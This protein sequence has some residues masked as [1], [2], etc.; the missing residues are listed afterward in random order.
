MIER[1]LIGDEPEYLFPQTGAVP[2]LQTSLKQLMFSSRPPTT[3]AEAQQQLPGH[4]IWCH[5]QDGRLAYCVLHSHRPDAKGPTTDLAAIVIMQG[6]GQTGV[7]A[8]RFSH[9]PSSGEYGEHDVVL[10]GRC[11]NVLPD[12]VSMDRGYYVDIND[13]GL[14]RSPGVGS[15][16]FVVLYYHCPGGMRL[17]AK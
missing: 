3:M 11:D 16:G 6:D 14:V 10:V 8:P 4:L 1:A 7:Q 13:P 2:G 17:R 12:A 5:E 15:N 9:K